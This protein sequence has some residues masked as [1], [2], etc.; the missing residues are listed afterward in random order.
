MTRWAEPGAADS[1]SPCAAACNGSCR[2]RSEADFEQYPERRVRQR[3]EIPRP[4]RLSRW[5]A[6]LPDLASSLGTSGE[7]G[8]SLRQAPKRINVV[9]HRIQRQRCNRAPANRPSIRR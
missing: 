5:M 2:V 7:Q 3:M 1:R 8:H 9:R 4:A 6:T